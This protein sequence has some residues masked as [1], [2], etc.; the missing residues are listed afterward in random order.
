MGAI[1]ISGSG[2]LDLDAVITNATSLSVTGTSN[3]G[4]SVTTTG[5]QT[6]T[7]NSTLSSNGALNFTGTTVSFLGT[8][9]GD[10]GTDEELTITG[11]AIFG[12][13]TTDTVTGLEELTITGNT[14]I[15]TT[16]ITTVDTQTYGDTANS[17]TLTLGTNVV[18][19]TG[20][21]AGDDITFN[22]ILN[23]DNTGDERNLTLTAEDV[24]FNGTVGQT[25]DLGAI[26]IT[27]NLD[28]NADIGNTGGTAGAASLAVS[29]TT[30]L[31]A[32]VTTVGAQVYGGV[33]TITCV[34]SDEI[35]ITFNNTIVGDGGADGLTLNMG[36]GIVEFN[37]AVGGT[38]IGA[39]AITGGLNLDAAITS[40][41]SLTVSTTSNLGAS[42]TTSGVQTYTGNSTLSSNGALNFTGTTVS[43][44]G[45]V[46]GDGGND[47]EVTITGNAIFGD[48]T[49]DTV[50]GLEE[51]TITG[52]T[53]IETTT[54]TT[55]DTQTYGDT[56]N[57][58][59]LT[60]GTNVVMTTGT[61]AGD[62]I[63]FNSILN[64][65]N[66][67]DE[68]NLTLTAEDVIF[69]GTVGQT[70]DL[71]IIDI[72]GNLDLNADIGN[73]G[74]VAGA[75]SLDVS[76]TT[77]LG[78]DV[79]TVG[80][81]VYGGVTTI[82][83]DS[84]LATT[85]TAITFNNT[86]VGDLSD[87]DLTINIGT[88]IVQF[89][90][91][92]GA[93]GG[94]NDVGAIAITGGLNLDAAITSA[95]SLTVS[96][97]SNLGASVTTSGLQTYTQAVTLSAGNTLTSSGTGA[98]TFTAAV[99]SD[100][101][102]RALITSTGGNTTFNAAVGGTAA[103]SGLESTTAVF[104]AKAIKVGGTI[105][106]TN[107]ATSTITGIISDGA[108][109]AALTK[110]GAGSLTLRGVNTYTGNTTITD[111]NLA[112]DG[113]GQLGSGTY[114]GTYIYWCKR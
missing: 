82:S 107:S 94:V 81:Q 61:A 56:A 113:A 15:E 16:T 84:I 108:S 24:I 5:A 102:A 41:T 106:I 34:L 45:T 52:N 71:G 7:G 88:G 62:D 13:A 6:Y 60:L 4:A 31:G 73:T 69:N 51:L 17:D 29:G 90:G 9:V 57:S 86:I 68:R 78:A 47:E 112:I 35:N 44:L 40:A 50:T 87:D 85:D 21:A 111:G 75:A 103:L 46:A 114:A 48:A 54:I 59:T 8:L 74:G 80:A 22:S 36:S 83:A 105:D 25:L 23:S 39:I 3:L 2:G 26:D 110:D 1:I 63:T 14:T 70:L 53:T 91:T 55:V 99:D 97:T 79:T 98:L 100:S 49:T 28:L 96:T 64:S 77:D 20:T 92:V 95:T 32:D 58:D 67:G 18:M 66:T 89:V 27:G 101:T 93:G 19:T 38:A 76:G 72:T 104:T 42:V 43:F 33:T 30:D 65:D 37:G 109:A 11:N 12:D 10:G